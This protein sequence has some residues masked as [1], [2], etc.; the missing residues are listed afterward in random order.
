MDALAKR[1]LEVWPPLVVEQSLIAA[2][3]QL[4]KRKLAARRDVTKIKMTAAARGLF[5]ELRTRVLALDSEILELAEPNSISFHGP[6][7]FLEILPRRHKLTLLL[8]LD[9]NEVVDDPLGLAKDATEKK[10]F[11]HASYEGGVSM[12]IWDVEAIQGALP[13]IRQA[14]AVSNE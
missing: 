5:E 12:S 14:H 10:F 11:V 2:A 4:E 13:L 3:D 1:S 6:A 7:F 8:A 9:F